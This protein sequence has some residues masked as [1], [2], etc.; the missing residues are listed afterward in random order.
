MHFSSGKLRREG[1]GLAYFYMPL[2]AGIAEVPLQENEATLAVT[3][4]TR[5]FQTA[6]VQGVVTYRFADPPASAAAINFTIDPATGKYVVP[7]LEKVAN[8]LAQ[9]ATGATRRYL[10]TVPIEEAITA[11]ADPIREAII[12]ALASDPGIKAM[13]IAIGSVRILSVRATAELEKALQTPTREQIQ[14]RADEATFQRRALA[15]EK[16]RA[17]KENEIATQIQLAKRNE[18][19]L[20]QTGANQALAAKTAAAATLI[21]V[22]AEQERAAIVAKG[23]AENDL[24][25]ARGQAE[26]IRIVGVAQ[27][28]LD[29]TR[30]ELYANN[31]RHVLTGLALR[32][33]AG[34]L[35]T[36][37]H[38]N[39]TPDLAAELF[40]DLLR[41]QG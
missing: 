16:E 19:L 6:T 34:K 8:F 24:I 27:G 21:T 14:Q 15:V 12:A 23:T 1:R 39:V 3:E 4:Q 26:S 41:K 10:V 20:Q 38:L 2:S 30:V 37:G 7:P 22:E 31:P 11:G 40:G 5:D 32:E 18:L 36:I 25:R 17:I 33:L 28:E 35:T 13:G 9:L 29:R